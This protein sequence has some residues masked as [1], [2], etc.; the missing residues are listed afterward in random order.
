M[1]VRLELGKNGKQIE[2]KDLSNLIASLMSPKENITEY[3]E[4]TLTSNKNI[5]LANKIRDVTKLYQSITELGYSTLKSEIDTCTDNTY[6]L[7]K[8]LKGAIA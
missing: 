5:L 6:K 8:E 3:P 4:Y 2:E 1:K 7:N